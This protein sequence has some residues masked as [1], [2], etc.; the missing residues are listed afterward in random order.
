MCTPTLEREV[1]KAVS[2]SI[3][4]PVG[5]S[6]LIWSLVLNTFVQGLSWGLGGHPIYLG[7]LCRKGFE[8]R[9]PGEE[10][11]ALVGLHQGVTAMII[12]DLGAVAR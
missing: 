12:M 11:V 8:P 6:L 4:T 3:E 10:G 1:K 7:G 5:C 2:L 9:P